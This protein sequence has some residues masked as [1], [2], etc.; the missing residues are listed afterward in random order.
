[1]GEHL[2][3]VKRRIDP[4]T[5]HVVQT[6]R[7]P[8]ADAQSPEP[9]RLS[10]ETAFYDWLILGVL[11]LVSSR[12]QRGRCGILNCSPTTFSHNACDHHRVARSQHTCHG[13]VVNTRPR[14]GIQSKWHLELRRNIF[15]YVETST[16]KY[17]LAPTCRPNDAAQLLRSVATCGWS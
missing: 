15:F 16:S 12:E 4:F 8:H 9:L 11:S 13:Y 6:R 17:H 3:G 5:G 14:V 7:L 2:D 1:M 10:P